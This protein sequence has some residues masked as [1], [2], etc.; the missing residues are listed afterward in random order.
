M[1][2]SAYPIERLE[3]L[4]KV[5]QEAARSAPVWCIFNNTARGAATMDA[6]ALLEYL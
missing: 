5:L 6:L 3:A 1:Y 2:Y 4:A